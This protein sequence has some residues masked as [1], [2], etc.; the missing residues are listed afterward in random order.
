MFKP[1]LAGQVQP[2]QNALRLG[3]HARAAV[4]RGKLDLRP[5]RLLVRP[6]D[7]GGQEGCL[8]AM[9]DAGGTAHRAQ[10]GLRR[11]AQHWLQAVTLLFECGYEAGKPVRA[12]QASQGCKR[13]GVRQ[14]QGGLA[15]AF[16]FRARLSRLDELEMR[17][18]GGFQWK[19]PQKR[20]AESVDGADPHAARQIQ[21]AREQGPCRLPVGGIAR[22]FQLGQ[23]FVQPLV[24]HCH[25]VA[26]AR[27]QSDRH[28]RSGCLCIGEAEDACGVCAREH[29]AQ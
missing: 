29:E 4:P 3:L 28:F 24:G 14:R 1:Q 2:G 20:L 6:G 16:Q 21:H 19:T 9:G 25:P 23:L 18:D 17:R 15:R 22:H 5:E 10:Q 12:D 7:G 8:T 11:Q 26:Q 27:L 13:F